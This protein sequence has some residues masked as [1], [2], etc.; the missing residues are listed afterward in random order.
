MADA[1]GA[2]TSGNGLAGL[3]VLEFP[4]APSALCGRL[5]ADMGADVVLV[6]PPGGSP[7]RRTP[8]LAG[9]AGESILFWRFHHGKRSV[10]LDL[11][12]AEGRQQF[13]ALAKNADVVLDSFRPAE[14][15]SHGLDDA[16]LEEVNPSLVHT[17][18]T[19]FGQSGPHA[20]YA[21][22]DI[23]AWAT[24]G[25]MSVCGDPA[26]EPLN[27]PAM[28]SFQIASL[29]ATVGTLAA[30]Y[31]RRH[32]GHGAR[33]DIAAQEAIL[34][35]SETVHSFWLAAK[36]VMKR[37]KGETL[38]AVPFRMWECADGY[39]F[40]GLSTQGQWKAQVEWMQETGGM[41]AWMEDPKF[42]Q[43]AE[44]QK[45]RAEINAVIEAWSKQRTRKEIW[46][47]GPP[48]ALPYAPVQQVPDVLD[49]PQLVERK[50]FVAMPAPAGSVAPQVMRP[51]LPFRSAGGGAWA[52]VLSPTPA[53][54]AHTSA[55]TKDWATP[56]RWPA[57]ANGKG[58]VARALPLHGVRI[59]EMCG[60]VAG[61]TMSRILC[62]LGADLVKLEPREV[63]DPSRMLPPMAEG[64][65][66]INRSCT[67]QDMNR[68]K[69]SITINVKHP[70][71]VA[72]T[73]KLAQ[74]ADVFLENFT[75]GTMDRLGLGYDALRSKNPR[76]VM[77]SIS[78]Y[79]QDGHR[80]AWPSFQ[81]TTAA[82]SGL[83]GL[84]AYDERSVMGFANSYMDFVAGLFGATG[85]MEALLRRDISGVGDHVDISQLEGGV[86][87]AGLPI[88]A[89]QVTGER[90][91]PEAN[92]AGA[93]GAALQGC[94]RCV[95][96]DRWIVVSAR[97]QQQ[98]SVL[99]GLTGVPATATPAQ[100][101]Q[102]LQA[103]VA[104]YDPWEAFHT[105]QRVGIA[106]GV[107][108]HGDDLLERDA[109]LK[110]RGL[111]HTLPHPEVG[112]VTVTLG[113][114]VLDGQR[115]PARHT[116]PLLGADNERVVRDMLGASEDQYLDY[117]VQEV[118]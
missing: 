78:G 94:Y 59:V 109:H 60:Q 84:F 92:R 69:R 24:G 95:G 77:A 110:E 20:D 70:E 114:L 63:G 11:H 1:R 46:E 66:G 15:A 4:G 52:K 45:R 102:A 6:E 44:R 88:V 41:P 79:G 80:T 82:L 86:S 38:L 81:P 103:W 39:A 99:A 100:V 36:Q 28:Q 34:D 75:G 53:P 90:P 105:L 10:T 101:E 111:F 22:A 14:L 17:S 2:P 51:G 115:L 21:A 68:N 118:V 93:V 13:A 107:V 116:A 85:A 65:V 91:L 9:S 71:G 56:S 61:P 108:E 31:R 57:G 3:R 76:L 16:A 5:L 47:Q 67:F 50:F 27:A 73:R 40:V 83:A 49:D 64:V 98:L 25:L 48:R 19:G 29:W 42:L 117:V 55:V 58:A 32:T 96:D 74:W 35:M 43:L 37:A 72:L 106:A 12:S 8:P 87:L 33:V 89:Y 30:L 23:V 97:D 104:Q 113:P 18:V 26:R 62:D 54:G 7:L 112:Q